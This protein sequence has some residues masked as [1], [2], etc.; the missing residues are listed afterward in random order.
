MALSAELRPLCLMLNVKSLAV[1]GDK[2][3]KEQQ[4]L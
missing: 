1:T 4:Q 3:Q 2:D